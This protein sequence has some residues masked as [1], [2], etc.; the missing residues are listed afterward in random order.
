MVKDVLAE[1][2]AEIAQLKAE[3]DSL[4][5]QFRAIREICYKKDD[6]LIECADALK[7]ADPIWCL[8]AEDLADLI[9]RARDAT[10]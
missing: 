6:L 4:I 3:N 5:E 1:K 8:S 2:D 10:K 7:E 9:Q